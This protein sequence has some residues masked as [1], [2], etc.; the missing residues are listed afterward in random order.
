[1]AEQARK[2]EMDAIRRKATQDKEAF[3]AKVT[4]AIKRIEADKKAVH[5]T[6]RKAKVAQDT[7]RA[8]VEQYIAAS[9]AVAQRN[10]S[11]ANDEQE[12][13]LA[14]LLGEA[15][16]KWMQELEQARTSSV[17]EAAHVQARRLPAACCC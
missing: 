3:D 17:D 11:V 9:V 1:M 7:R 5:A 12:I 8:G 4:A 16:A 6:L 2:S 15:A 14:Q 10:V 13:T